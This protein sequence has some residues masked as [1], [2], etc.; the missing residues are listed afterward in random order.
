MQRTTKHALYTREHQQLV[1]LSFIYRVA[2]FAS[3]NV[4][5]SVQVSHE[6]RARQ[7]ATKDMLMRKVKERE[8]KRL[9]VRVP[10]VAD[11]S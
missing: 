1:R 4:C 8:E 3:L 7:C 9:S 10:S 6:Q 11:R 2:S 5:P